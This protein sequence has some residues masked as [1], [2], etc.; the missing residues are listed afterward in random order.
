[1]FNKEMTMK[2]NEAREIFNAA[3][4]NE[5]DADRIAMVEL[6][7]EY[8]CNPEMANADL[9]PNG[10][11]PKNEVIVRLLEHAYRLELELVEA[12]SDMVRTGEVDMDV[13]ESLGWIG[14]A[15]VDVNMRILCGHEQVTVLNTPLYIF[16]KSNVESAGVPANFNDGYGNTHLAGFRKLWGLQ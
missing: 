7:R 1:M 11:I 3:I 2:A 9:C 4:A 12:L 16:D 10:E 8:F 15:G 6:L 14:Y 5:T 13:G